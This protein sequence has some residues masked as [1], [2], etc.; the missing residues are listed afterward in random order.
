MPLQTLFSSPQPTPTG[1][2]R[3]DALRA[4]EGR[5]EAK[6]QAEREQH[7]AGGHGR[8]GFAGG[9]LCCTENM[10]FPLSPSSIPSLVL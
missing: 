5:L 7:R 6:L 10:G 3:E 9:V 4:V 2:D 1:C 8:P